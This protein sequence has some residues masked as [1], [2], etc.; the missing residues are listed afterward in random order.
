MGLVRDAIILAGGKGTR[1][2]PASLFMPKEMMPLIDTP[3]LNHL[4]W[5]SAKAG[6]ERVHIV[7]S[8]IKM[9][10]LSHFLEEAAVYEEGFV[11]G[12]LP[13]DSLS[14]GLEG[15]EI[16]TH[17]QPDAGGV[18]DAISAALGSIK[19]PFLVLLGDNLLI[20]KH[21][22]PMKSGRKHA[23]GA[24]L[25]LVEKFEDTGVPCV[26]VSEVSDEELSKF[27]CVDL[28]GERI[29]GI[30]EKPEESSAPS[31]FVLS[32]RYL[33]PHDSANILE[34]LPLEE[35]GEMQSISLLKFLIENGGLNAVNLEGYRMYDSG[36]PISWLK[37][38]ID[39]SLRRE[40][41]GRDYKNWLKREFFQD[42]ENDGDSVD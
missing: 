16:I 37:S 19:G 26:G 11:R 39:H 2:L 25:A 24:S 21:V 18:G 31:N 12:D 27:G 29:I 38:Q 32:G 36:D 4:V 13:K 23:S 22:G 1:M 34:E 3:I 42:I 6:V 15:L 7:V 10:I 30:V 5:E 8:E 41:F 28:S 35:H 20:K 17:L 33:L 40:D 14:L 9:K